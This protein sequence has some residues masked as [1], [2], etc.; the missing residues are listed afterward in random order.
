MPKWDAAQYLKFARQRTRPSE[1]LAAAIRL[2]APQTA[3]DAGCGPGNSTAVLAARWPGIRLTGID[4]S[5][6]MLKEARHRLPEAAFYQWDLTADLSG[7]GQ[8]DV[9]FSNAALQWLADMEDAVLRLF[10][11]VKEGGA[12]AVQVPDSAPHLSSEG[13]LETGDAHKAMQ[14]TAEE[15][16]FCPYTGAATRLHTLSGERV[17]ALLAEQC[18]TVD[19]W[20]TRYCHELDGYEGLVEW[21]RGTGM[22]PYLESLPDDAAR[23]AFE[24]RFMERIAARYSLEPNGKLLFWFRRLFFIAYR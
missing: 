16:A 9:V 5:E 13:R 4:L 3:L 19:I 11:L 17:Y 6:E 7:L 8:F 1:D 2:E 21:Y 12:L 22:R 14:Q 20:E 15:A 23:R 10:R 24:E 18:Q